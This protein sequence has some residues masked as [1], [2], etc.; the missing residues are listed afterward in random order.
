M[1][2]AGMDRLTHL[3]GAG[4]PVDEIVGA[5]A[6][7]RQDQLGAHLIA[8]GYHGQAGELRAALHRDAFESGVN[9]ASGCALSTMTALGW[10]CP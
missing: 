7:C 8:D 10:N 3:F 4:V 9:P 2:Q 5:C 1:G 6:Q